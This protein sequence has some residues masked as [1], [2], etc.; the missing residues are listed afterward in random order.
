MKKRYFLTL[1]TLLILS[2]PLIGQNNV[3]GTWSDPIEFGIVPVAVANLPDGRL[4]TWS[5]QFRTSFTEV[6]DGAT[7]SQYFDPFGG[8]GGQGGVDGG[9]FT[10]NTDH[11]MFCPGINNLPDGRILSAGGTS[12]ERTSIFDPQT[13]L[14][15]VASA[16]NIPRGYQGNVTLS[17][18]SVFTVGGSWNDYNNNNPN[19]PLR[20][21]GKDAEL[22]SPTT[23]WFV[24]PNITGED[25]YTNNDLAQESQGLYRIDN[26]VWLWPAPN[27][28][29]FHAGPGEMMHW[30][31]PDAPGGEILDAGIREDT[32]AGVTDAYSMKGNTVMFDIGKILK[33]GGA[34]E[35]GPD[36]LG[37]DPAWDNSFVIDL[38]GVNYGQTPSVTFTG[39]MDNARTMHNSTVLPN[40]EVLITGGLGKAAVFTDDTAVLGAEIFNP[41]TNTWRTVAAM[42]EA[43]TYHS[44]AIL[45]VDGRVFVGGGGLCN[46]TPSCEN[47]L[48][49]EIY[50][51]PYLYDGTGNLATRPQITNVTSTTP[52]L[53]PYGDTLVDYNTQLTVTTNVAV[54]E[55]ALIRFSAATHST[56]NEQRRIPLTTST[57][58]NH[59]LSIPDRNLLPPGYYMLFALDSNGVPSIASTLKIGDV[60]PLTTNPN[61]VLD[62]KFNESSGTA[63]ADSSGNNNN[64]TIIERLDDGTPTTADDHQFVS[65]LFDNAIEFDGLEFNSN[66][67]IDIDYDTSFETIQ[68]QVTMSA[69]VWRD[70]EG[71]VSQNGNKV[72]NVSIFSHN[73]PD[74][75]FGFHNTLYKWSFRTSDGYVN[76]YS[77]Y[78]PLEGWNHIVA[79][80]DGAFAKLY[81]NGV[82]ISEQPITGSITLTDD[83]TDYSKFTVSGFHDIRTMPVQ[84]YGNSS[85]VTDE[86]DGKIDELQIFNVALGPEEV[87]GLYQ[88]GVNQNNPNVPE[89]DGNEIAF[90][91][92]I[93][94]SSWITGQNNRFTVNAGDEVF[95]R[96]KDY[97]GQY[98]I[99]TQ[100]TDGP[101]FDSDTELNGE[102]AYQIDTGLL[103]PT[104]DGLVDLNDAGIYVLTTSDGCPT[105]IE[106]EVLDS[107]DPGDIQ[108]ITE[109]QINGVWCGNPAS[110][111]PCGLNEIT[112]T[113]GDQLRLSAQPENP[114]TISVKL[115]NGTVVGNNYLIS[116]V[117]P[118]LHQGLYTIMTDQGC[119]EPL[120][121]IIQDVSCGT[122][123]LETEYRVNG[124]SSVTGQSS[125]TVDSGDDLTLSIIP[126]G[127]LYS[128]T[129]TSSNG[130]S[131]PNGSD[132]LILI[133]IIED[134]AGIYTFTTAGGCSTTLE[135]IVNT[136]VDCG[137]FGF[138]P[139]Y[140][141]NGEGSFIE[142]VTSLS[143]DEGN[144]VI[145]GVNPLGTMFEVSS[146]ATNGNSKTLNTSNLNL[147]DLDTG[148]SGT[149]TFTAFNG[150]T[151]DFELTIN[152][153]DCGDLD[154]QSE[155][156]INSSGAT[157]VGANFV[158][159]NEGD[160]ITLSVSPDT[161][162]SLPLAFTLSGPNGN[163]KALNSADFILSN[164]ELADAGTYT[165][166]SSSGCSAQLIL[167]VGP[168]QPPVAVA[169]AT[170]ETG[171]AP[172]NVSFNGSGSTD[173]ISIVSYAWDFGDTNSANI[174]NP[175][176]T[177]NLP[178]EYT[179]ILTVTDSE[180]A[181]DT[182]EI[183]I[184]V[185]APNQPPI[186]IVDATPISG[187]IP[188][189][190]S[191][192]SSGSSDD[193][194]IVSYFWDFD[195]GNT[196]TEANPTHTYTQLGT[197]TATLTVMDAEGLD[198]SDT[199][200][201]NVNE[202]D[203]Q[204]PRA[205][206][207]SDV[208]TGIAPLLVSFKG[209]NSTDDL[210][211]VSYNWDF[212]DGNSST[213]T[214]P[215]HT[216]LSTGI[217]TASLTVTDAEGL[218]DMETLEI[219][220][221]SSVNQ[222]PTAVIITNI[223]E[224]SVPLQVSFTGDQ[225]NDTD[226]SITIYTW[227]FGDGNSSSEANPVHTYQ[228]TGIF[229]ASL[230]VTDNEGAMDSETVQITVNGP[231]NESPTAVIQADPIRGEAPLTVNFNGSSSTDDNGI[232]TY[233]WAFGDAESSTAN[234]VQTS[235]EY[236]EAGNYTVTLQVADE[237]G[238][239]GITEVIV[240]V[241]P[242]NVPTTTEAI[243]T[244]APNPAS[245]WADL[246]VTMPDGDTLVKFGIFDATGRLIFT[247]NPNDVY[248][249]AKGTYTLPIGT[250][251]NGMYYVKVDFTQNE[252]K[253]IRLMVRN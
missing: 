219:T 70:E 126:D 81:A 200:E 159:I 173:D 75:F 8:T 83:A 107:C 184:S 156:E 245:T 89:C 145:L 117:D 5:S 128:I 131:K 67:I 39:N 103:D 65:G 118:F 198:S 177:Y 109:Y 98:F 15:T 213:E 35:Y 223:A 84:P 90:E 120:N 48:N 124:G 179:A 251:R 191:F 106:L 149:Y 241:L 174:A 28:K 44:V 142:G 135:V 10:I 125:V 114:P 158:R 248:D 233:N 1:T 141:I 226:G 183:V 12:S 88:L 150:C 42:Q 162:N 222:P 231:L 185:T 164:A 209:E 181:E 50:S 136:V 237:Q 146:T 61:L 95:I 157:I 204:P 190:V 240:E 169:N 17:N 29:V 210:E 205:V 252:P 33:T 71:R 122:L 64:G 215:A 92:K 243:I 130:N 4:L 238:E 235:F 77:G 225:S 22:W 148:D 201:I 115:P 137:A 53:G 139:R 242:P 38:N 40:G 13:G 23:G 189:E 163:N 102:G 51:P 188:L 55:F 96:A 82:K 221:T 24:L 180:G 100:E 80:Y 49:A 99:T 161:Y 194:A 143:V 134:D 202:L 52:G 228:Q 186:A 78:A 239:T 144:N 133:N 63:I 20:N 121:I 79:T 207:T 69:W 6:G 138:E 93:N 57:G 227:D 26:H 247:F 16:M 212:G 59:L 224:G 171:D 182:D 197:F 187:N 9:E 105:P 43:R 195:D 97:S 165:F 62:F 132:D 101:T 208:N 46:T 176:H 166:A 129:S 155:Y 27:G 192:D 104:D 86:I 127:T 154:L 250:L 74:I 66:S 54:S 167:Y 34:P 203:N 41:D 246:Y 229:T 3:N 32:G 45:M 25:L 91:Y 211:I 37:T 112:L 230:T 218:N 140:Q 85:G 2:F 108:I 76:C 214:N 14:W 7:F 152:T 160:N 151:F 175:S 216:Y 199:I 196:S 111:I 94:G 244:A 68:D 234:S 21:G 253:A 178:G 31:D 56:N 19:N 87:F 170:P 116:S 18:G 36:A 236:T 193:N 147:T 58:T 72:A 123:G 220:V 113:A 172:L 153:V 168:N 47:H 119:S 60:V 73:Y 232:S 217:F 110:T 206:V 11:D 30:I 249:D